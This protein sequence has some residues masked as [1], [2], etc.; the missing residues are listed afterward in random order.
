MFTGSLCNKEYNKD[1]EEQP[2][3]E[4]HTVRSGRVLSTGAPV[5]MELG[6]TTLLH[7][8]VFITLKAL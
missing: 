6:C 7:V 5:S 2:D 8:D 3:T 1:T 4:I